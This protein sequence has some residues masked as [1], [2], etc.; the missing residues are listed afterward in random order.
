MPL[1]AV[2]L[3][4]LGIRVSAF[5]EFRNLGRIRRQRSGGND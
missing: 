3:V 4:I 2:E 1:S 5:T